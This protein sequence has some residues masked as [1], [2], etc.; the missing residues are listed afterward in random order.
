MLASRAQTL[1]LATLFAVPALA[2]SACAPNEP[3]AS[4]AGHHTIG[5]DRVARAL[6]RRPRVGARAKPHRRATR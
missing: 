2:L 3:V 4:A 6:G 1:T 5:V